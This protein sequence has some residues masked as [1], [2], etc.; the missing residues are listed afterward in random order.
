MHARR[1]ADDVA[2]LQPALAARE[3]GEHAAG[4]GDQQRA[5]GDVP[6]RK[7]QLEEAVEDAGGGVGEIERRRSRAP[8][9]FRDA[10]HFLKNRAVHRHELL[11]AKRKAGGEERAVDALLIRNAHRN[12]VAKRARAALGGEEDD[13][14]AA[15]RRRRR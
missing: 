12:A 7:V 10:D 14:A 9:A 4:L 6:R 1:R 13:R 2:A 3:V 5:G 8:H 11:R 15:R